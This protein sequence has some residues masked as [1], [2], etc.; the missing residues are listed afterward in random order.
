MAWDNDTFDKDGYPITAGSDDQE[1][2]NASGD[3]LGFFN[4]G[5]VEYDGPGKET[6]ENI[7]DQ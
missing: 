6:V 3:A 5:V 2:F 7:A 1:V 4:D